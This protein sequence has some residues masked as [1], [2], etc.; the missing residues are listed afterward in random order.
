MAKR[1]KTTRRQEFIGMTQHAH[2]TK[3]ERWLVSIDE[4]A[5]SK[6]WLLEIDSPRLYLAFEISDLSVLERAITLLESALNGQRAPGKHSFNAKTDD[7]GLG[8]FSRASVHL[9]RDNEDFPRCFIVVGPESGSMLRI[10]LDEDSIRAL[11]EA[12]ARAKRDLTAESD[13]PSEPV[14]SAGAVDGPPDQVRKGDG[15]GAC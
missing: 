3:P 2:D 11:S 14:A 9:L 10:D 7:V 1:H 4:I 15:D 8:S 12:L 5:G 13:N 6:S